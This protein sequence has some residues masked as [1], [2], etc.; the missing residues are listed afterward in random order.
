MKIIFTVCSNN[1]LA[2]AKALGDSVRKFGTDYEFIIGL[3]DKKSAE[4]NYEEEIGFKIVPVEEIGIPNFESLCAKFN[5]IELNTAVKPFYLEYFTGKHQDLDFLMYFDPDT[6]LFASPAII[7]EELRNSNILIT[8]HILTP[9]P[10]DGKNPQENL[11]LNF[12]IYNLGFIAL[13]QPSTQMSFIKWWQERT[14]HLGYDRIADGLFVDQLW[15]NFSP[16]FHHASVSLNPGLN[17]GPWNLHERYLKYDSSKIKVNET[18]DLIFYHFSNYKFS[19][20][21]ILASY[22]DR[23]TFENRADLKPLYEDYLKAL[24]TNNIAKFSQLKCGIIPQRQEVEAVSKQ[25]MYDQ[26]GKTAKLK[27]KIKN[28]INK[29]LD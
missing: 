11:F 8:P 1:Y 17:M 2:Q 9:V 18:Y 13:R 23:F 10:L 3:A 22:Y 21:E 24:L 26:L 7:E 27:L 5:I 25:E 16:I 20:P 12:G 14:Y 28:R 29:Y 19:K 15:I 4:I 6:A